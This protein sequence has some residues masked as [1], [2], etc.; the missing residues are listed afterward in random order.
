[1]SR[2][3]EAKKGPCEA[4]GLHLPLSPSATSARSHLLSLSLSRRGTNFF[5]PTRPALLTILE[6]FFLQPRRL[7]V[8]EELQLEQPP[9]LLSTRVVHRWVQMDTKA[10][11]MTTQQKTLLFMAVGASFLIYH[12]PN[13]CHL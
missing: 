11:N 4:G 12:Q 1:M 10:P 9:P 8:V 2:S 13:V 7:F 3:T 6:F 5:F